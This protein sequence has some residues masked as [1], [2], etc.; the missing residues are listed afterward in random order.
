MLYARDLFVGETIEN[1]TAGAEGAQR[2]PGCLVGNLQL[3]NK[4]LRL[5]YY[6]DWLQQVTWCALHEREL[7]TVVFLAII[8]SP[9]RVRQT[10]SSNSVFCLLFGIYQIAWAECSNFH[11]TITT[12]P[13]PFPFIRFL[14]LLLSLLFAVSRSP[15]LSFQQWG[16]VIGRIA[17]F[18]SC[19]GRTIADSEDVQY[20][21]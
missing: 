9:I 15:S 14:L 12:Q 5:R 6:L 17:R 4:S 3:S 13:F 11:V 20:H 2:I 8:C 7:C 18:L 21:L 1:R 16:R 19:C 10:E